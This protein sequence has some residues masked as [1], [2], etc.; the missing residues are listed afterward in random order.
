MMTKT[1]D[2]YFPQVAEGIDC[3]VR[4]YVPDSDYETAIVLLSWVPRAPGELLEPFLS[5]LAAIVREEVIALNLGESRWDF[6]L[7]E[8]H[9][10]PGDRERVGLITYVD[11]NLSAPF[12]QML[13][14]ETMEFITGES[15]AVMPEGAALPEGV[16]FHDLI[17]FYPQS[18]I[19]EQLG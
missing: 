5:E 2:R 9:A 1:L 11:S 8:H 7:V 12:W 18:R 16:G 19:L 10:L 13:D 3:Q 6:S 14:R 17:E 15:L 4:V